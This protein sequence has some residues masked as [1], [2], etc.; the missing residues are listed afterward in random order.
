M[1]P[2]PSPP[3]AART[4]TGYRVDADFAASAPPGRI[5]RIENEIVDLSG[6]IFD[7]CHEPRVLAELHHLL[8]RF[9]VPP[10]G[11]G[12]PAEHAV[13]P[14]AMDLMNAYAHRRLSIDRERVRHAEVVVPLLDA[15]CGDET[16]FRRGQKLVDIVIDA[17]EVAGLRAVQD[18]LRA[19]IAAHGVVVEVNPSSNLLIGD[20]LDL[21]NHPILRL[22]PPQP[23][24]GPPP[25]P[26]AVGSDDPLTFSTHLLRALLFHAGRSAGYSN[27]VVQDWLEAIRQTSMDARFTLRWP[28][29]AQLLEALEA[30][31]QRP[32]H[33][34]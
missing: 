30:Y 22:F 17:S 29:G 18:A 9:L 19:G 6:R 12:P 7:A 31:L 21:R 32:S 15:Y 27:K 13:H 23:A 14:S 34:G 2:P 3:Q 26:I 8:Q 10:V 24:D 1:A 11:G 28:P 25:V 5:E 20:L 4:C 33:V 16:R